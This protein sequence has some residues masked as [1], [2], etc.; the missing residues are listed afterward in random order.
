MTDEQALVGAMGCASWRSHCLLRE[1]A[2]LEHV[3]RVIRGRAS[4]RISDTADLNEVGITDAVMAAIWRFGPEDAA[5]A[6]SSHAEAT[7]LGADIAIIHLASSRILLYQAK[8][9]SLQDDVFELKSPVTTEQLRLLRRRIPL[10]I[11]GTGYQVTGRLALYQCDANFYFDLPSSHMWLVPWLTGPAPFPA[12]GGAVWAPAPGFGRDYYHDVLACRGSSPMGV[13][14]AL[15]PGGSHR[16]RSVAVDSTWPWE[17]DAHQWL[18]QA[19]P[20]GSGQ[21]SPDDL[22]FG[23]DP[24]DFGEYLPPVIREEQARAHRDDT[25]FAQAVAN[26]LA[27]ELQLRPST[28]LYVIALP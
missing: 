7:Q 6:V 5:Y 25:Q 24:P 21:P 9:A 19:P 11:L 15:I 1:H 23:G 2:G 4:L 13:L 16:V 3:R 22:G 8:I 20:R 12:D 27:G 14:A 28:R 10:T 26:A 18:L 17:F